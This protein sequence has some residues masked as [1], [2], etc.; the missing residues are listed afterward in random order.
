VR[1]ITSTALAEGDAPVVPEKEILFRSQIK[2]DWILTYYNVGRK[3]SCCYHEC[4]WEA[5][6]AL[7]HRIFDN[8]KIGVCCICED[9]CP[10][11]IQGMW[12]LHNF[13]DVEGRPR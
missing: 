2:P 6:S 11:D 10:S 3:S 4:S 5:K 12:F 9:P 1:I 8:A 13:D 7:S